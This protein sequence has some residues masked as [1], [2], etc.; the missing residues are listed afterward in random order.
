[1]ASID[2]GIGAAASA[3]AQGK[4][5]VFV[6][7]ACP[8]RDL[9]DLAEELLGSRVHSVSRTNGRHEIT[10]VA[11]GR[12]RFLAY[13]DRGVRGIRCDLLAVPANI[14][15]D[16]HQRLNLEPALSAGGEVFTY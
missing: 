14:W 15:A 8:G 12:I 7:I 11:G 9:V 3:A 1:M 4:Q 10:T 16:R 2:L 6:T 5:A 13:R